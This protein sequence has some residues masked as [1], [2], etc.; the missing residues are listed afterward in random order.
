[1][2]R[3]YLRLENHFCH[4]AVQLIISRIPYLELF[5]KVQHIIRRLQSQVH[6]QQV[7]LQ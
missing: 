5:R 4:P 7:H 2:R 6:Q 3:C 1:M